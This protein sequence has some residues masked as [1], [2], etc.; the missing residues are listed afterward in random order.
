MPTSQT[1]NSYHP[2]VLV[3]YYLN[4]LPEEILSTIP[5]STRFDWCQRNIVESFGYGWFKENE[6]QF[7]TT[8][9]KAAQT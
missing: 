7:N 6:E 3:A 8:K 5:R 1:K 9:P 2:Y 4:S